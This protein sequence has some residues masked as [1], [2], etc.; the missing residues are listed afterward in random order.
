MGIWIKDVRF[1]LRMLL[2]S[3]VVTLGAVLSLS[4]GIGA[5][6]AVFSLIQAV[7]F[8]SLPVADPSRLAAIYT[9]DDKQPGTL[10]PISH[11]NFEDLQE[12]AE[13][14]SHM[15]ASIPVAAALSSGSGRPET[16]PGQIVSADYFQAF[17][18][19][20][21]LGRSLRP[22]ESGPPG[23]HPVAVLSHQLWQRRFGGSPA[24]IN[25]DIL[26]N[27]SSFTVV[28]VAP[29][30]FSGA[31]LMGSPEF[32]A[33]ISM[34]DQLLTGIR[35]RLYDNRRGL[36]AT[37]YAKLRP[38]TVP[39]QAQD[40][41]TRLGRALEERFPEVNRGRNFEL[42]PISQ[43][44]IDPNQRQD[45]VR[46]G[47]LLMTVVGLVLLVACGNVANLFLSRAAARNR[48]ISLRLSLGATPARLVRQLL[49]ESL[50]LA[51]LAGSLGMLIASL[52]RNALW[53]LRPPFLERSQMDI[54][55]DFWGL[56]FALALSLAAGLLFGLAPALQSARPNLVVGLK[57]ESESAPGASRLLSLRNVLVMSQIALSAVSLAGSALFLRSLDKAMQ[58]DLG[59]DSAQLAMMRLDVGR[60]GYSPSQ[61]LNFYDRALERAAGQPQVD[62]V[63][64]VNLAPLVG[65][66]LART[67]LV[68]GRDPRADNNRVLTF[69]STVGPQFFETTGI[70]LAEGR[71]FNAF[72]REQGR[73][74]AIINQS[75]AQRF[76][77]GEPA[78]GKRFQFLGQETMRE[79][80]GIVRDSKLL[81]IGE[82]GLPAAYLPI[83]QNPQTAMALLIRADRDLER[84]LSGVREEIQ[85][86]DASLAITEVRTIAEQVRRELWPARMSARLLGLLGLVAL[87]LTSIGI[88]GVASYSVNQRRHELSIRMALGAGRGRLTGMIL[89]QGML[90][91]ALGLAGGVLAAGLAAQA[92]RGF[93][94]GLSP[95]DAAAFASTALT[96]A[97]VALLA[98][99]IPARRATAAEPVSI[100]R[101]ER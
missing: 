56:A 49:T 43:A 29:E 7:F 66:G 95:L 32:W 87:V 26:L 100:M 88:Y 33:P 27:G 37:V 20:A 34:Y 6:V 24:I 14:F 92:I 94:F 44:T 89:R 10:W 45:F 52:A 54:S 47:G 61:A 83:R 5:N 72:D 35:R 69:V 31:F 79:V 48:E 28:G 50:M 22:Q 9:I 53:A 78:L 57:Q 62:S 77:P 51:A 91:A 3:P 25:S 15:V 59:F 60:Q 64:L 82:S 13:S 16:I 63:T 75:M 101:F 96:L 73:A 68:E 19:R 58:I 81:S 76:W 93:L 4:L 12:G 86:L 71:R 23:A 21:A 90:V 36:M 41:L 30:S 74:V 18:V 80:V 38:G 67:V 11:L 2:K 42:L 55:F 84:T 1:G 39:A 46:A 70:P 97:A 98:N 40:E 85:G 65:G 8:K 17:G 99:W